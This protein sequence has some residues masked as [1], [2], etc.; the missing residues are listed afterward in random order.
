MDNASLIPTFFDFSLL[1]GTFFEPNYIK[2]IVEH[3][4]CMQKNLSRL[5]SGLA[6]IQNAT[7][8]EEETVK[9]K[10]RWSPTFST[11]SSKEYR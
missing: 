11:G 9:R 7:Q 1:R 2:A 4:N 10:S 3:L 5:D 8:K 6:R